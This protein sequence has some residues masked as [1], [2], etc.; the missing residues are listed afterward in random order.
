MG[1]R[2]EEASVSQ[3]TQSMVCVNFEALEFNTKSKVDMVPE[4][5]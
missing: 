1:P 5:C 2:L 4:G 3:D